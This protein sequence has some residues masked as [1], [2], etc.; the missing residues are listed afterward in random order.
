MTDYS[1]AI[2]DAY[3]R[4]TVMRSAVPLELEHEVA[5]GTKPEDIYFDG[6]AVSLR[7]QIT[8]TV[9]RDHFLADGKDGPTFD[10]VPA[11]AALTMNGVLT[12]DFTSREPGAAMVEAFGEYRSDMIGIV[13]MSRDDLAA[14]YAAEVDRLAGEARGQYLTTLPGQDA[15]YAAKEAEARAWL[16]GEGGDYVYL[17][18]DPSDNATAANQIV[19]RADACRAGLAHIEGWRMTVKQTIANADD[20][21]TM[22]AALKGI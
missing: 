10:G 6:E 15:V 14:K 13:F 22:L 4:A 5:R 3:G 9:D 20:V 16:A 17:T 19:Q 18:A 11:D 8:I 21:A 1:Y 2:F 7:K 12:R